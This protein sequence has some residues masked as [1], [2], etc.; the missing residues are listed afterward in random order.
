MTGHSDK[1]PWSPY[2]GHFN[3]FEQRMNTHSG[4][5]SLEAV[6]NGLY[7][8]N[9]KFGR[10][11]RIFVCECYSFG[12]AEYLEATQALGKL[13]AVVINSAWC[14]YTMEAKHLAR[15]EKVGIFKIGNFM[16]A[17]NKV[18]LWVH[19]TQAEHDEFA[20]KGWL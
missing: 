10:T 17:L 12:A 4:V 5:A 9:T 7:N 13:D 2:Y 18:E 11:L 14:S 1:Y 8:L 20:K 3:F 15:L 19:L 6:G 16:S